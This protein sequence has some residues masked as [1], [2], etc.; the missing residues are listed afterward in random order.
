[1]GLKST[2]PRSSLL[3]YRA[4]SG[5]LAVLHIACEIAEAGQQLIQADRSASPRGGLTRALGDF[6]WS[7]E[8]FEQH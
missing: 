8:C 6:S 7:D 3:P 1:M 4:G 5:R 2:T